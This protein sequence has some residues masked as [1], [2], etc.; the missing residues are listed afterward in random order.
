MDKKKLDM[1]KEGGEGETAIAES[2]GQTRAVASEAAA[3]GGVIRLGGR[4]MNAAEQSVDE[5]ELL[6][7]AGPSCRSAC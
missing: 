3:G 6:A 1:K 5:A 2:K 7:E 4:N